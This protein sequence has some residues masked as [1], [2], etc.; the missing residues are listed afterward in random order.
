[1][2]SRLQATARTEGEELWRGKAQE[3]CDEGSERI[4]RRARVESEAL[5]AYAE[6]PYRKGGDPRKN[7]RRAGAPKGVPPARVRP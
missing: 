4:P 6:L 1:M 3:G 7:V 5:K 2:V